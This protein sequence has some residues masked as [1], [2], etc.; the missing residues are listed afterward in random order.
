M[1]Y[2]KTS[3]CFLVTSK[4]FTVFPQ[5]FTGK[6]CGRLED[7]PHECKFASFLEHRPITQSV[8]VTLTSCFKPYN[9]LLETVKS[10]RLGWLHIT[11]E[12]GQHLPTCL[13]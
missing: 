10:F 3:R 7:I 13:T 5:D 11:S 4:Y 9:N 6:W 8:I 2:I 12:E 1:L